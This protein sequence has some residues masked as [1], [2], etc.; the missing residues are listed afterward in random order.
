[1]SALVPVFRSLSPPG[2]E[3]RLSILMF[4]RVLASPDPLFPDVPDVV[5]F[6]EI[7]RWITSWFNVLPL[8]QAVRHLSAGTL[9]ARAAA[10]TFDDG[11]ADNYAVALPLLREYN[12]TATFF[13]ATG[14]IDGGRMWNDTIIE[15]VRG[16]P[17]P[18]LELGEIEMGRHALVRPQD[19]IVAIE[20]LIARTKY[21]PAPQ[22]VAV[23]ERIAAIAGVQLPSNLMLSSHEVRELRRAGMQI[24][25]HT[26]SHPILTLLSRDEAWREIEGSKK[27]LE[28]VL[29]DR[30]SL[31]AYPNGRLGEDYNSEH[32]SL[33]REIG[34]EAAAATNP[35]AAGGGSD[36]MQLPRFTPWDRNRLRFGA[37]LLGNLMRS[38]RL[39][40]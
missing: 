14:F 33:V 28:E 15:A 5:R 17:R 34:F 2:R 19:R 6:G 1:M 39:A 20:A 3:A 25:A 27:Q 21:L 13:I 22:R 29:G 8:D 4:H 10:I 36:L 23:S 18:I 11:Y 40:A 26:I 31:F 30:V 7:L 24:G 32:A 38:R 9:P 16:C 35:G 37:R 12:L